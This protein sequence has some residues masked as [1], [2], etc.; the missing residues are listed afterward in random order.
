MQQSAMETDLA[1]EIPNTDITK[2]P[3]SFADFLQIWLKTALHLGGN[4]AR[5]TLSD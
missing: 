2:L 3:F 4:L 5:V 1:N